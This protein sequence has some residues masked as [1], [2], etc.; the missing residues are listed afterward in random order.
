MRFAH[1]PLALAAS[2]LMLQ[3][4]S[5]TTHADSGYYLVTPYDRAGITPIDL[6]SWSTKSPGRPERIWPELGLS[7]GINSRW[8]TELLVSTVGPSNRQVATSSVQWH[9]DV[10]LTQG[11]WPIDLAL[12]TLLVGESGEGGRSWKLEYGPALQTEVGRTQL[13]ANLFF[14][15]SFEPSAPPPIRLKYQW[16]VRHHWKPL[17]DFGLQGFGEVGRWDDWP[18]ASQQP[19]R[20]GPA[21]FGHWDL[22]RGGDQ[23]LLYQA[24]YLLGRVY[25][26][27]GDL[28]TVRLQYTF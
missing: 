8:T 11:Q 26:R 2:A 13:N 1:R 5:G 18:A 25:R 24:A 4:A 3:L 27:Q 10:M 21:V 9:N 22:G 14:E 7:R 19:H 16:Q 23:A 12:H 20:A 6:R 28:F 17:M 15:R